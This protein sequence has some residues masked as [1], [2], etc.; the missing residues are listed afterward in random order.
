MPN[1]TYP[2]Q[3]IDHPG[4]AEVDPKVKAGGRLRAWWESAVRVLERAEKSI[5]ENFRVPPN[6]G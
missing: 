4:N 1:Q 6:G 2:T 3:P 5:T